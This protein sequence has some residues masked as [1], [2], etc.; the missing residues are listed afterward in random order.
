MYNKI[1]LVFL[2]VYMYT[3]E[4]PKCSHWLH[5]GDGINK[6]LETGR[7][8]RKREKSEEKGELTESQAA[9]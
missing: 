6:G 8:R 3:E 4:T 9:G 2:N 5:L 1:C 7:K